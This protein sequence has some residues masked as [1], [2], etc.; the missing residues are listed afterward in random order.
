MRARGFATGRRTLSVALYAATLCVA[1]PAAAQAPDVSDGLARRHFD[2]GVAYLEE[3]DLENALRA[4]QKAYDL[5]KRSTI[6]L[7]IATVQERRGDLVAAIKALDTY[8]T[9]E[10]HGEHAATTRL[11]IQNLQKRLDAAEAEE[12]AASAAQPSPSAPAAPPPAPTAVAPAPAALVPSPPPAPAERSSGPSVA[13]YALLGIGGAG[14]LTAIVTGVM[15]S[16]EYDKAKDGCSPYCTRSQVSTSKTLALIS[17]V[18]TGV[19]V[20]GGGLG[21]TLLLTGSSSEAAAARTEV[22]VAVDGVGPAASVRHRF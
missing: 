1:A 9:A 18:A 11:R 20:V 8:L 22:R 17:T 15:A 19:A 3:S 7:N 10:P 13:V 21:L 6:L 12:Q 5:S 4:F 2:S 14:T 16:S